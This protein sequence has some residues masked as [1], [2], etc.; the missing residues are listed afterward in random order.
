LEKCDGITGFVASTLTEVR[1]N[2]F[3]EL[4]EKYADHHRAKMDHI[5]WD[6]QPEINFKNLLALPVHLGGIVVGV[7]KVENRPNKNFSEDDGNLLRSLLDPVAVA[8]KWMLLLDKQEQRH[9]DAPRRLTD[10]LVH[11]HDPEKLTQEIVNTTATILNAE[12]CSLWT[13]EDSA[14]GKI[15]I[16]RA[17]HG[18]KGSPEQ[19]P[20]YRLP[21]KPDAVEDRDIEG[22]TA[23]VAARRKTF[24]AN[25]YETLSAHPSWRGSWDDDQ[26]GGKP[27]AKKGFRSLYAVPLLW[28]DEVLGVLKVENPQDKKQFSETDHYKAQLMANLVALLLVIARQM[29]VGLLPEMAHIL[30]SPVAGIVTNLRMLQDEL[31]RKAPNQ[32]YVEG[33]MNYARKAA[34]TVDVISRTLAAQ[35]LRPVESQS[36][37]IVDLQELLSDWVG[38]AQEMVPKGVQIDFRKGNVSPRFPL[39]DIEKTWVEIIAFNLLPEFG[40]NPPN[41]G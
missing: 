3:A 18:F 31:E 14:G 24:W 29:R 27:L 25:S 16:H 11:A 9:I 13:V 26:Y 28:R 4:R 34:M 5:Q 39:T 38:Y 30:K 22:I 19:V 20:R 32:Q 10:A 8:C 17:N 1:V 21:D 41:F 2:S 36:R 23:W 35:M 40:V 33:F 12:I 6:S 7:L 37:H 15:L